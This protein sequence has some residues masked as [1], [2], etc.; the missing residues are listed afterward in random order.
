MYSYK[1]VVQN[2][3]KSNTCTDFR[4]GMSSKQ[5][6]NQSKI[7]YISSKYNKIK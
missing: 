1:T 3:S 7:K 2:S 6:S 5:N 4:Y